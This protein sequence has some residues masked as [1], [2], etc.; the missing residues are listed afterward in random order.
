M[1]DYRLIAD[2]VLALGAAFLGGITA[3]RLGQPVLIGYIL[4]G[5]LIGPNTPGFVADHANVEI[6]ANLGVAFLM[7][8]I[9]VE[10]SFSELMRVRRVALITGGIQIPL[11]IAIGTIAGMA[12][13]WSWQAAVLLGGGFAISS[14]IVALKLSVSR[15]EADSPQA[16]TALGIG[17]VQDLSLVPMI[18][19]LPMLSGNTGNLALSL[20]R[21]VGTAAIALGIVIVLGT[22]LVPPLLYVVARTG[23]RELFLLTI[24]LIALGTA[25]ASE[26]AGLSL[27]L[28]A[29]LAGLVVSESE[30]DSHVLAE[31]IPLRDLFATLFFV[32]VGMLLEPEFIVRNA[33]VVIALL[34][35]LVIGKL[36]ITG[37]ALL[38]AGANYRTSTLAA[39]LLAQMGEFSFV[40]AGVGMAD[41]IIGGDQYGIFLGVAVGSILVSPALLRVTPA[42][43]AISDR[44]PGVRWKEHVQ[45]GDASAPPDTPGHVVLCGYGRVGAV[46]GDV[47]DQH[48]FPY[49]VVEINP[50]TV[51]ELR[52]RDV[53]AFYGDAGSDA[54]LIRAGIER[55]RV[56]VVTVTDLVAARAAIRRARV[57]N[58][59]ITIV[60]RATSRHEVD[61][62]REAGADEIIQPE[63]EAGLQFVQHVLRRIGLS[64]DETGEIVAS[65]RAALYKE[66]ESL[67]YV[68][69]LKES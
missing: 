14:T 46:L 13:G 23:S 57:L 9:G 48:A 42:L 49:T 47:L 54:L 67:P 66:S 17:I 19:I 12:I 8:T 56:L 38:A 20:V 58:P 45:V 65:R 30:F 6:L 10:L 15:G 5:I 51:R 62:H 34:L 16:R 18:A 60:T 21:S 26:S 59:G 53:P 4:A 31:I 64:S 3:H 2:L 61:V 39:A 37:G 29:F 68:S 11:T 69:R 52:D 50:M 36:L 32:A 55:A 22:R 33:G 25:L 27:A 43:V 40:L 24:V 28:G 44:L 63:Y 7:F 1:E 41:G 35:T